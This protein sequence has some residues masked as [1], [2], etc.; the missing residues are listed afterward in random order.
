MLSPL[1]RVF[2]GSDC[3]QLCAMFGYAHNLKVARSTPVD[4]MKPAQK[5]AG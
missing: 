5:V 4:A 2:Y 3:V 1:L